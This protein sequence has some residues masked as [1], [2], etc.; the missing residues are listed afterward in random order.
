MPS[1]SIS[2]AIYSNVCRTDGQS[3]LCCLVPHQFPI[4]LHTRHLPLILTHTRGVCVCPLP[5][6]CQSQSR[7][8]SAPAWFWL[9]VCMNCRIMHGNSISRKQGTGAAGYGKLIGHMHIHNNSSLS[10]SISHIP[11]PI[12]HILYR[13]GHPGCSW[14]RKLVQ[15]DTNSRRSR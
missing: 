14:H 2:A 10:L 13:E 11:Y 7:A 9:C 4:Y 5:L 1:A 8:H 3:L 15:A 6:F 12:S